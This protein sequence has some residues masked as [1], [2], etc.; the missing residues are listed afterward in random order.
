MSGPVPRLLGN[1]TFPEA[2]KNGL[3]S[4][5]GTCK[6]VPINI[7]AVLA[8]LVIDGEA[9]VPRAPKKP[10]FLNSPPFGPHSSLAELMVFW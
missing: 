5:G 8:T 2:M 1:I 3:I 4:T 9:L 10:C 6:A 7:G